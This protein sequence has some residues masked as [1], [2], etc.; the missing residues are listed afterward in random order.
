M[1]H[2]HPAELPTARQR[3]NSLARIEHVARI[4]STF[5]G[6][7]LSQLFLGELH[8]HLVELL[9]ATYWR[10]QMR[11]PVRFNAAVRT[12][13]ESTG[14]DVVLEMHASGELK[15]LLK[16]GGGGGEEAP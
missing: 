1:A 7:K 4:E 3:R 2:V 13:F 12:L 5:D 8:A 6:K 10:D 11:E 9:D 16:D 14:C 15:R